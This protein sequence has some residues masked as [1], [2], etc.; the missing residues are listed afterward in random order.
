MMTSMAAKTDKP[1]KPRKPATPKPQD[2]TEEELQALWDAHPY[3]TYEVSTEAGEATFPGFTANADPI[4]IAWPAEIKTIEC[5]SDNEA[6]DIFLRVYQTGTLT[7]IEADGTR[8]LIT[9]PEQD[10]EPEETQE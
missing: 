4:K 9:I 10:N 6:I 2:R 7:R 1:K 3:R 8:R 5:I